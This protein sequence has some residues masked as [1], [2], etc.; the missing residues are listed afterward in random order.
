MKILAVLLIFSFIDLG[1]CCKGCVE[2]SELTFEKIV[3]KFRTALVKFDQVFPHGDTHE[4]FEALANEIN[5]KT[6]CKADHSD[7]VVGMV[8]IK[9][10][11]E[12]DNKYLGERFG[13]KTR[14]DFPIIK[15]FIDGDL[16]NA[17][18]FEIG[19]WWSL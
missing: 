17:I 16:E 7:I 10:Y 6:I 9:D 12:L 1:L 3:K 5:N 19:K 11:G 18:H 15:L 8:S 14:Y 2:L 4:A 13:A